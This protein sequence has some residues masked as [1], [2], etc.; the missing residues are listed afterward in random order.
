MPQSKEEHHQKQVAFQRKVDEAKA[1][2]KQAKEQ[3][4]AALGDRRTNDLHYTEPDYGPA[5][6][7]SSQTYGSLG[8]GQETHHPRVLRHGLDFGSYDQLRRLAGA[9]GGRATTLA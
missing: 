7:S 1:A 3:A 5:G 6:G 2:E 8:K 9:D 4:R